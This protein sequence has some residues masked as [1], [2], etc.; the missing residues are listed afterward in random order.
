M[1]QGLKQLILKPKIRLPNERLSIKLND[2]SVVEGSLLEHIDKRPD[3]LIELLWVDKTIQLDKRTFQKLQLE[4]KKRFPG[5]YS[6]DN[7]LR[8]KRKKHKSDYTKSIILR[9]KN[10]S[11][12]EN[13]KTKFICLSKQKNRINS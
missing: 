3:K 10:F 1:K 6:Q 5:H 8:G 12:E 4:L 9:R 2:G 7:Q 13:V 11:V